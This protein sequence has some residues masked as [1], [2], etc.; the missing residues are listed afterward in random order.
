[1][2]GSTQQ[3]LSTAVNGRARLLLLSLLGAACCVAWSAQYDGWNRLVQVNEAGTLEPGD[4]LAGG[5][6]DPERP[7]GHQP[8]DTLVRFVYD[9]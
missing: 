8:G 9:P 7:Q 6:L 5:Q 3:P 1:V 2:I 4:F